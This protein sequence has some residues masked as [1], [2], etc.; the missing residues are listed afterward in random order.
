MDCQTIRPQT[1]VRSVKLCTGHYGQL[2]DTKCLIITVISYS[3]FSVKP[4]GK[5]T[6]QR[7]DNCELFCRWIVQLPLTGQNSPINLW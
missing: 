5:L 1:N 3:K 4:Y 7:L 6:S 2:T